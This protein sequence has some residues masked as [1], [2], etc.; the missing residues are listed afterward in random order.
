LAHASLQLRT[1]HVGEQVARSAAL[2]G[3]TR[4]CALRIAAITLQITGEPDVRCDE[5]CDLPAT[6]IQVL[7]I[8]ILRQP[9][10]RTE[11]GIIPGNLSLVVLL[12]SVGY[13]PQQ[14]RNQKN[15]H[16]PF[17]NSSCCV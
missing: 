3:C 7:A 4:L 5:E 15:P 17:H 13:A 14:Q 9:R 1:E 2:N 12:L 10:V 8:E 16:R 11:I 6:A